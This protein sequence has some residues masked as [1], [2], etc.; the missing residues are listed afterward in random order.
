LLRYYTAANVTAIN[1]SDRQLERAQQNAPGCRFLNMDA[2]ELD[3]A[4]ASFD[5]ILCVESAFHFNTRERFLREA[6]RVL[7]PEGNLVLSDI[8]GWQSREKRANHVKNPAAYAELL[9]A[10]GFQNREVIDATDETTRSCGRR[11]RQWPRQA[12]R[13]G[14]L[15]FKDYLRAWPATH[16]YALFMRC[17]QRYY[18]LAKGHRPPRPEKTA[19]SGLVS[20][21]F[22]SFTKLLIRWRP[23]FHRPGH[24]CSSASWGDIVT[25]LKWRYL[26]WRYSSLLL[27][28]NGKAST[29]P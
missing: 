13:T 18:L 22:V 20:T 8:L 12:W 17:S 14:R 7:K 25:D 23:P 26:G 6:F 21:I 24:L 9:A 10:A 11:L 15:P 2:V 3:F 1:I 28:H 27:C 29:R 16:L 4:D 19:R 5:N